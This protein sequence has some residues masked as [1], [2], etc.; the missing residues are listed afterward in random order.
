MNAA[1]LHLLLTHLPVVGAV[2]VVPLLAA[3]LLTR[4]PAVRRIALAAVVVVALLGLP[5]Y[6]TGEGAEDAVDGL[7]G[8]SEAVVERHEDAA[9]RSLVA[10]EAA[11]ALALLGLA[12]TARARRV[13]AWIVAGTLLVSLVSA[14]LLGW[15][16]SLGGQIRHTE[17]RADAVASAGAEAVRPGGPR[18]DDD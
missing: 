2:L 15:T 16:A 6:F 11:G 17:I 10:L 14:G 12:A 13:P 9:G 3:G 7:P 18:R 5:T 4:C 1:H 8:V